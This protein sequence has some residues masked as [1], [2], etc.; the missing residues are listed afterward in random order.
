ME[1]GEYVRYDGLGLADLVRRR[2]VSA[3][4]LLEAA[5]A[6]AAAVNP[7]LNAIVIP[8]TEIAR[9]RTGEALHGPFAGVPFLLK[10]LLQDYAGAPSTSGSRAFK[11]ADYRPAVHA[12]IV[13]RWLNA[14][15]VVFGRT[16]SPEFGSK[17]V[18]EPLAWGPTRN[19]WNL[20]HVSGGSSGGSASAV[21]A[22]IVP[23]A[24]ASDGGGSIRIP[25]SYCG[26]FG[27]KPG[28]GR[29]PWGPDLGEQMHGAAMT[30]VLTRSV[31]DSAA[32]L[33]ATH[34]PEPASLYV[35]APPAGSYLAE[36][37]REPEPLRIAFMTRSPI[38]TPLHP[39][40]VDAVE[41]TASLLDSLG[42]DVEPAAPA[43]DGHQLA[44]DFMTIW[45]AVTAHVLGQAQTLLGC[46]RHGFEPDTLSLAAMGRATRAD[47]YYGAYERVNRVARQLGEF[48]QRFDLLLTPTVAHPPPH[49]GEVTTPA[50]RGAALRLLTALGQARPILRSGVV[51]DI[52]LRNLRWVPFTQLA[53]MTGVPAMSMPLH[54]TADGLPMGV[55]FIAPAGAEG[56]LFRLA[57]QLERARPWF[58]RVPEVARSVG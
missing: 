3:A 4:E 48:H 18:T 42:H 27:F 58:D 17:A 28:R 23:I 38:D 46:G 8:M 25:A 35:P 6:R 29:T 19:P 33:D 5:L 36:V 10:D 24:G 39:E 15:V 7:A 34:G 49:I 1:Y 26:L 9:Q 37:S 16:N 57:G 32:M 40:A 52:A 43:I 56:M 22:G 11:D 31:R 20:E 47:E 54:W 21:A 2:E 55:Q 45:F 53:N 30:H 41:R 44:R 51:H 50:W 12:E 14:G 13:K